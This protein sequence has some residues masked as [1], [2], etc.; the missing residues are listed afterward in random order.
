MPAVVIVTD[1]CVDPV[2]H[3]YACAVEEVS[4]TDPPVPRLVDPVAVITGVAGADFIVTFLLDDC[5]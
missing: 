5:A 3:V 1:F 2:V 4:F